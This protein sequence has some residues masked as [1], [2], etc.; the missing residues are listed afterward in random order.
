MEVKKVEKTSRWTSL[1]VQLVVGFTLLFSVVFAAAFYWFY[2]FATDMALRR[3]ATDLTARLNGAAAGINGDDLVALSQ[4]GQASSDGYYSDDPRFMP[5][6]NWLDTVHQVEPLA[7]PYLY[8]RKPG[9]TADLLFVIDLNAK[10]DRSK[11]AHF[12]EAY[13]P[14]TPY[15]LRGFTELAINLTPYT[16]KWGRW[17]SGYMPL[18][19]AQGQPVAAIGMDFRADYLDEVQRAILNQ[20]VVAF[21]VTYL[22]LLVLVWLVSVVLTAPI[23]QLTGVAELIG[24]GKYAEALAAMPRRLLRDE[25]TLLGRV[26]QIMVDKVYQREQTLLRQVSELKIEID[27]VKRQKQVS[28]IV[29]SDFFQALQTKA[30]EMR[31]RR[32]A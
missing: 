8:V 4:Q 13:T 9:S 32:G 16:D 19:N 11:A 21:V 14:I 3:I 7:W 28:E 24:E 15:P 2:Q 23:T 10:Y 5:L 18:K 27:E 17:V 30:R 6:L 25:I 1:R 12:N 20:V 22:A 29:E 31:R 26:F